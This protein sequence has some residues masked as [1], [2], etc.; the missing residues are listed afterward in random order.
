MLTAGR[1]TAMKMIVEN[2]VEAIYQFVDRR[3]EVGA[4]FYDPRKLLREIV[5]AQ[6]RLAR[7]LFDRLAPPLDANLA[8]HRL[9]GVERALKLLIE[10]VKGDKA[11]PAVWQGITRRKPAV[12]VRPL[13]AVVEFLHPCE[14]GACKICLI[15]RIAHGFHASRTALRP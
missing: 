15:G 14:G 10:Q 3:D 7:D 11:L 8:Q 4:I 2:V 5:T 13:Q 6:R 1:M 12:F 9:L